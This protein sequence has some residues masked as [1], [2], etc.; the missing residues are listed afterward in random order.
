[1]DSTMVRVV[2]GVLAILF[3]AVIYLRR[4]RSAE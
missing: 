3:G 2:C 4:R 1:M